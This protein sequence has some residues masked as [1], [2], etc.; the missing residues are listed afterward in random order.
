MTA[1]LTER[2][3]CDSRPGEDHREL[4]PLGWPPLLPYDDLVEREADW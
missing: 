1:A 3:C 2:I 4:C